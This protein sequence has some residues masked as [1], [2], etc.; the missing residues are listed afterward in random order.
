[1]I[2][3]D[4]IYKNALISERLSKLDK[5]EKQI[6]ILKLLK[7]HTHRGL[8]EELGINQSTINDWKTLRQDNKGVNIHVSLSLIWRKIEALQPEKITDWGR[9]EMIK[10]KCEELLKKKN[11]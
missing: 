3:L 8:A 7:T 11:A 10:D 9:I 2:T 1:M 6:I 5:E 4:K